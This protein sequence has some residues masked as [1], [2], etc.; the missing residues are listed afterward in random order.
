MPPN[1]VIIIKFYNRGYKEK[2]L[3]SNSQELANF[4]YYFIIVSPFRIENKVENRVLISIITRF[5]IDKSY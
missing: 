1:C 4:I 2:F 3:N 5:R